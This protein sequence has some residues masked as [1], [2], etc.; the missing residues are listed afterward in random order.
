MLGILL[1]QWI[2]V[3]T[4]NHTLGVKD[5]VPRIHG[6]LVL[7]CIA[8]EAL[9]VCEGNIGWSGPVALIVGNDLHSA[10][11][12]IQRCKTQPDDDMILVW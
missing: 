12:R 4:T 3:M 6:H 1:Q 2:T 7:C 5:C 11:H 10:M 8:N 9:C